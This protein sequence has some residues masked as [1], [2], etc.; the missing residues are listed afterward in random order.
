MR[1]SLFVVTTGDI[2][3]QT[4]ELISVLVTIVILVLFISSLSG[5]FF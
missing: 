5:Y 3:E 4:D 2:K 1:S